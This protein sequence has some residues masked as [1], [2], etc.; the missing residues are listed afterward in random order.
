MS[1][2]HIT[3]AP[4]LLTVFGKKIAGV[5]SGYL[6]DVSKLM[7]TRPYYNKNLIVSRVIYTIGKGEMPKVTENWILLL[8]R[9]LYVGGIA[10]SVVGIGG[11]KAA[12]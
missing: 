10:D 8:H 4:K 2:P 5:L 9:R 6:I 7:N 3:L 11:E 1:I 12:R